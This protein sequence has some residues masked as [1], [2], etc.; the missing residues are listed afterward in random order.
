[1]NS[2]KQYLLLAWSFLGLLLQLNAAQPNI[3]LIIT[4]DQGYGDLGCHGH[5]YARTPHTDALAAQSVRLDDFH[6]AP[7]CSPTRAS[8]MTGHWSNRTGVWHTIRG[9]SMLRLNETTLATLLKDAGYATGMFG[10]WHLGDNFPYR[11]EDRGFTE[12]YRHGAG[13]VG[14][15]PDVWDNAY[16]DGAYFHNKKI[17][18]AKGFC[19]DVFFRQANRFIEENAKAGKPFFAY[20]AP[21]APHSPMH[22]PEKYLA[23]YEGK[24]KP[25]FYAM[26]TNIDDNLG[27]TRT[28]LETL[29]VADNTIFIFMTDN[30][31]ASG[32]NIFNAG[33]RGQKG[34][35]F[36]GG[37]RVPFFLHWPKGEMAKEKRVKTLTHV[38]DVAPTLLDMCGVT[39]PGAIS[40]D[41]VSIRSLLE[42]GDHQSWPDRMVITDSQRVVD[43]I[44]WR[45]SSVMSQGWRLVNGKQL[46]NIDKD[47]G[48]EKDLAN[49]F[50]ERVA[51]MRE[52]YEDWWAELT[53]TYSQTTELHLGHSDEPIVHLTAHDWITGNSSGGVPWNQ[54]HIRDGKAGK[55]F[56][57][58]WAVNALEAGKYKLALRRWPPEVGLAINASLPAGKNV[59]V[60][61][62]AFRARPGRC[63]AAAEAVLQIDGKERGR[64]PVTGNAESVNFTVHLTKGAH[65]LSPYFILED[66]KELGAYFLTVVKQSD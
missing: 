21:N 54:K 46:Y 60:T 64:Q 12:V 50:P 63:I 11:P 13:G 33:M 38:V 19:T 37:H 25:A 17:V 53:P 10:K 30:G 34:S 31:T 56:D 5:P 1:M 49:E 35:E 7:T 41:G 14:Q 16:F 4:D 18:P 15:T 48:Q 39:P 9:R 58:Y 20:I 55:K 40:F 57:G 66:G 42:K 6:A 65:R 52:F 45:K 28:L 62:N 26:I 29:G 61:Q 36:D 43:P 8:L 44:K 23:M 24:K 47:P 3:V 2:P 51:T 27:Q 32:K 59:P 22:A